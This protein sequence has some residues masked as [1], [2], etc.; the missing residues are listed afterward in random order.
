MAKAPSMTI[1][2]HLKHIISKSPCLVFQK[3]IAPNSMIN[4]DSPGRFHMRQS[5]R[6]MPSEC[7]QALDGTICVIIINQVDLP[8]KRGLLGTIFHISYFLV[9]SVAVWTLFRQRYEA[10][11]QTPFV[12]HE[13]S[14]GIR[15]LVTLS[16]PG[17]G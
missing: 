10:G 13:V 12:P 9:P 11:M 8:L 1:Q 15:Y 5:F 16:P 17:P 2:S 6:K 3:K 7:F 4:F 14:I